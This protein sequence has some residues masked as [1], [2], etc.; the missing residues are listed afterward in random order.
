[1]IGV[2]VLEPVSSDNN[3]A[4]RPDEHL[5]RIA[6]KALRSSPYQALRKLECEVNDGMLILS[7][8]VASY[9]LKQMAQEAMMRLGY[10]G[11]VM[12][13]VEVRKDETIE[14]AVSQSEFS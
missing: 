1:M 7:G 12:N 5:S 6:V 10:V 3:S 11:L 13:L 2:N 8:V 4:S 9:F 14:A